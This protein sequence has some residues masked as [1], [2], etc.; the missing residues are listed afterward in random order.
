[1]SDNANRLILFSLLIIEIVSIYVLISALS[2][3]T[4]HEKSLIGWI[5]ITL[6]IIAA[7]IA[8]TAINAKIVR[9][10]G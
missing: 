2:I 8:S 3:M 5:Q 7:C 1:M 10:G 6:M 9:M 4:G